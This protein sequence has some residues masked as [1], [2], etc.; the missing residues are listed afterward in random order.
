MIKNYFNRSTR[1]NLKID[2]LKNVEKNKSYLQGSNFCYSYYT[3][4]LF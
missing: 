4:V 2:L 1:V 3:E